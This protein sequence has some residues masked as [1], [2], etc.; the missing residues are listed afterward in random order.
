MAGA[1]DSLTRVLLSLSHALAIT[2]RLLASNLLPGLS[3]A[4]STGGPPARPPA[5]SLPAGFTA[6]AAQCVDGI[7]TDF[8]ILQQT[9]TS[10]RTANA[11]T[12]NRARSGIMMIRAHGSDCSLTVKSRSGASNSAPRRFPGRPA[13]A[14]IDSSA[15]LTSLRITRIEKPEAGSQHCDQQTATRFPRSPDTGSLFRRHSQFSAGRTRV[16][17]ST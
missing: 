4:I 5:R 12:L 11:G 2:Q 8:A 6:I 16:G 10:A 15:S 3:R 1:C 14:L 13:N 7:K 9:Q 17:S